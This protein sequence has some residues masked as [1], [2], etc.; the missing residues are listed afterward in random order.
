MVVSEVLLQGKLVLVSEVLLQDKPVLA[1]EVLLFLKM[2]ILHR[3]PIKLV[4]GELFQMNNK[5]VGLL[6]FNQ[7]AGEQRPLFN[8]KDGSKERVHHLL[9]NKQEAGELL[10]FSSNLVLGELLLFKEVHLREHMWNQVPLFHHKPVRP[11]NTP[12]LSQKVAELWTPNL[13]PTSNYVPNFSIA[14]NITTVTNHRNYSWCVKANDFVRPP[15]R[16]SP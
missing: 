1:L 10:L 4:F 16:S 7:V 6:P 3:W 12:V 11:F 8:N 5:I 15:I 14:A 13:R 9:N 2:Q